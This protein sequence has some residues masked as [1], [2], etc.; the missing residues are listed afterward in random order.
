MRSIPLGRPWRLMPL[1]VL[2]AAGCVAYWTWRGQDPLWTVLAAAGDLA[3]IGGGLIARTRRPDSR[4][5]PL[6]LAWGAYGLVG[7]VGGWDS[8]ALLVLWFAA[9]PVYWILLGHVLL[10]YPDGRAQTRAERWFLRAAYAT[11]LLWLGM[12]AF[13]EPAWLIGCRAG[14]CPGNPVLI[15]PSMAVVHALYYV[16]RPVVAAGLGLWLLAL[17]AQRRSRMTPARRRTAAPVLW[18]AAGPLGNFLYSSGLNLASL[19]TR[20]PHVLYD[21]YAWGNVV[22]AFWVPAALVAGLYRSRLARADVATMLVRLRSATVEDLQAGLAEVLRDPT[23]QIVEQ[24][25]EPGPTAPPDPRVATELGEGALLLHHPSA[26]EEDPE[27]FDAA[28]TAAAVTLDNARLTARVQA[29]L[30]EATA[31]RERLLH[32]A[33]AERGRVERDLHDGAQQQ[34]IGVGMALE[35]ARLALPDHSAAAALLDDAR[36]QLRTTIAALRAL[37]RGL[38][39]ALLAERGLEVALDELRRR[40]PLPVTVRADLPGRLDAAAET[41]AYFVVAEALQNATKHA[42]GSRVE[43]RLTHGDGELVVAVRD[44]GPGGAD[45]RRGTGLRGLADRVAAI[46]GRL[47]IDSPAGTGTTVTARVP[48]AV[49]GAA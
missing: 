37:A 26:R 34:L 31:S 6:L 7:G 24:P 20:V 11:P 22:V 39:P 16:A 13:A 21:I 41:A 3:A 18:A 23:L 40:A 48:A 46:G 30:A 2:V 27:L 19:A 9:T 15:H 32:A 14:E 35:S 28:V 43:V 44:D 1:A 36:G 17:I 42:P 8:G 29:Q 45:Q 38:R 5:G 49:R 4:V 47:T 25:P 10:T 12:A 33:D